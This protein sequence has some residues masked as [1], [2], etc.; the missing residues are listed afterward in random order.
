MLIMINVN[1]LRFCD[2]IFVYSSIIFRNTYWL[3]SLSII[4]IIIINNNSDHC[5]YVCGVWHTN[6]D[7]KSAPWWIM[8][9][10]NLY[11]GW[12][13]T[14]G[15][16]CEYMAT[17]VY[18]LVGT[19]V[20]GGGIFRLYVSISG[21]IL[22][23]IRSEDVILIIL[24]W[25]YNDFDVPNECI[26]ILVC[27]EQGEHNISPSAQLNYWIYYSIKVLDNVMNTCA[28]K[29]RILSEMLGPHL[30]M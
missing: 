26:Y 21:S 13:R 1:V 25:F 6:N 12:L 7:I 2:Y 27:N 5:Y 14:I 4:I 11:R 17:V 18:G 9:F 24:L 19:M 28:T 29:H 3:V 16:V 8:V 20:R 23:W 22:R 15:Y 30:W 10:K